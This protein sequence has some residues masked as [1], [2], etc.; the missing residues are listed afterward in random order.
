MKAQLDAI[1]SLTDNLNN[2]GKDLVISPSILAETNDATLSAAITK[3][4]D[5]Q[6]K[7]SSLMFSNTPSSPVVK[8]VDSQI[9][10]VRQSIMSSIY[11]VK[12]GLVTVV[13]RREFINFTIKLPI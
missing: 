12:K 6:Q 7:R 4:S 3:L 11:A 2:A 1:N 10:E 9:M 5:L 8:E 13:P